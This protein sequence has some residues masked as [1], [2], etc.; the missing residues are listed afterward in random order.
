MA[1]AMEGRPTKELFGTSLEALAWATDD[2]DGCKSD[3]GGGD[4]WNPNRGIQTKGNA[5]LNVPKC[6]LIYPIS[7]FDQHKGN[8]SLL[9]YVFHF[10]KRE[11]QSLFN[12]M[13]ILRLGV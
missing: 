11:L 3:I 5:A 2:F 9:H 6:A 1:E 10:A 4:R 12:K 13:Y 8:T 7:P